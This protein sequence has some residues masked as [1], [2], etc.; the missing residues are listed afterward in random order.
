METWKDKAIERR[1]I[2]KEQGKRKKE[3]LKSRD[4]WKRKCMEQK[5]KAKI[6]EDELMRIKKNLN[7][8]LG[9]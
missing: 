3:L 7:K 2:N 4:N 1:L 9:Q 6:L 5:Q 8:I